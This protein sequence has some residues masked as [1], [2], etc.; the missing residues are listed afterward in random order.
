[1]Y[2]KIRAFILCF[3]LCVIPVLVSG[4]AKEKNPVE[5]LYWIF[6]HNQD[7][8]ELCL[9]IE[10][11][12][13]SRT[14]PVY[15]LQ[16]PQLYTIIE[17]LE[18]SAT[19]R[20][21]PEIYRNF[22]Q[23]FNLLNQ[24][25]SRSADMEFIFTVIISVFIFTLFLFS[26]I[27]VIQHKGKEIISGAMAETE[28]ERSRVARDLHDTIIQDL[29]LLEMVCEK[30]P[31]LKEIAPELAKIQ[32]S[33][34]GICA[35]LNPPG[36]AFD[37]FD[38]VILGLCTNFEKNSG[39]PCYCHL[40]EPEIFN[41]LD[42]KKR[43]NL[44]RLIQE[45]LNNSRIHSECSKC[46]ILAR[47]ND[48]GSGFVLFINDDGK[49]FDVSKIRIKEKSNFGLSGMRQRASLIDA[50]FSIKSSSDEGTEIRIEV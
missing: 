26:T 31:E 48:S 4:C 37:D 35:D 2:S 10:D 16:F 22:S 45:A 40:Q 20:N 12:R 21:I 34:R 5:D 42:L 15:R 43:L 33:I 17:K 1:M 41:F 14:F 27:Y 47:K 6:E 19:D 25:N 3:F 39:I 13:Q 30:K 29:R 11:F 18:I 8:E 7:C 24:L 28:K 44:Y 36:I 23:I 49:G 50:Q 32:D 46:S 38:S 9:N